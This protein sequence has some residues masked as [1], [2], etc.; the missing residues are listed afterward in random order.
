MHSNISIGDHVLVH[1]TDGEKTRISVTYVGD[2]YFT[3]G[4]TRYRK[5]N[6]VPIWITGPYSVATPD[7][8]EET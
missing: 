2:V 7:E 3:A 1:T 6:G 4:V 5:S 8:Q